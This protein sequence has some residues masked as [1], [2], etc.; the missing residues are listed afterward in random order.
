MSDI[1]LIWMVQQ[2]MSNTDLKFDIP[3]LRWKAGKTW[4][5]TPWGCGQWEEQ[6]KGLFRIAGK[7]H[8][9]P[10]RY[11]F[12]RFE[13][14]EYVTKAETFE[15]LHASLDNRLKMSVDKPLKKYTPYAF[16]KG[17]VRDIKVAELGDFEKEFMWH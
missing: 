7:T 2:V 16:R 6:Y 12:R 5:S 9:V 8:R 15:E 17:L 1:P 13:G 10:G 3:V 4:R 11:Q 14:G